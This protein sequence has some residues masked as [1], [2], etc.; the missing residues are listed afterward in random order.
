[1]RVKPKT[2][3]VLYVAIDPTDHIAGTMTERI[4]APEH[5]H[6]RLATENSITSTLQRQYCNPPWKFQHK[7]HIP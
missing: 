4:S 5:R 1:M 7:Y 3:A 6:G 2:R